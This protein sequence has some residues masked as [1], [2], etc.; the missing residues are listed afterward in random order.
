MELYISEGRKIPAFDLKLQESRQLIEFA[1]K[2]DMKML[3]GAFREK[4]LTEEYSLFMQICST[5]RKMYL[6]AYS[7]IDDREAYNIVHRTCFEFLYLFGDSK[8]T[9]IKFE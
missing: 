4:G 6:L 9:G 8:Y 1:R 7:A 2:L 5:V 3:H